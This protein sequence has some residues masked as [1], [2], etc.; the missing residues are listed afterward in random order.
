METNRSRNRNDVYRVPE[1][2]KGKAH[3]PKVFAVDEDNNEA[4]PTQPAD[5]SETGDFGGTD[6]PGTIKK[7]AGPSTPSGWLR[8][9]GTSYPTSLHPALFGEIGY[10]YGGSGANFNV[11]DFR[12]RNPRGVG[13]G[14]SLGQNEGQAETDRADGHGDHKNHKHKHHHR[15]RRKDHSDDGGGSSDFEATPHDHFLSLNTDNNPNTTDKAAGGGS[16]AGPNHGHNVNGF[17]N[18]GGQHTH[19]VGKAGRRSPGSPFIGG[20]G[21][22]AHTVHEDTWVEP[23]AGQANVYQDSLVGG[24]R[25]EDGNSWDGGPTDSSGNFATI[26][27]VGAASG[28]KQHGHLRVHFIIKT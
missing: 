1:A 9:N 19:V 24:F 10:T 5:E 16:A 22:T 14:Q 13:D 27:E 3:F 17:T 26:D 25:F 12:R 8:C 7:H 20:F 18:S 28:H 4:A 6:T 11:P 15:N 2:D 23:G 21:Q